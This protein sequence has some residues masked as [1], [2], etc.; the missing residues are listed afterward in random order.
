[1]NKIY[2]GQNGDGTGR[3][4]KTAKERK[5]GIGQGKTNMGLNLKDTKSKEKER[6]VGTHRRNGTN[7]GKKTGAG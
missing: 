2:T 1:M 4:K 7:I 5:G 3:E 6:R